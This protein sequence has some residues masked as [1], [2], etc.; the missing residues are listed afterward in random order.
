MCEADKLPFLGQRRSLGAQT[1]R[2]EQFRQK[3]VERFDSD[4]R[5]KAAD[6]SAGRNESVAELLC[7]LSLLQNVADI[8]LN[9]TIAWSGAQRQAIAG[10][11]RS[12]AAHCLPCQILI[13][14]SVPSA[15]V[16][17]NMLDVR[18]LKQE[19]DALFGKVTVLPKPFNLADSLAEASC[20]RASL[21]HACQAILR[22]TRDAGPRNISRTIGFQPNIIETVPTGVDQKAVRTAYDLWVHESTRAFTRA[23]ERAKK[24]GVTYG[25][26][27]TEEVIYI[28][29]RYRALASLEPAKFSNDNIGRLESSMWIPQ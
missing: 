17:A 16:R 8:P 26:D 10:D 24:E 20:L 6:H 14:G 27:Y 21:V 9:S 25:Q 4:Y 19:L 12:D 15:F 1:T 28:L 7:F 22:D 11:S 5:I 2:S 29:D 18:H 13:N 23:S 3:Q